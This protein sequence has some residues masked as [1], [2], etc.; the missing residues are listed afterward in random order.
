MSTWQAVWREPAECTTD[1]PGLEVQDNRVSGSINV[2]P[3][4]LPLWA[5]VHEVI[6][7]GWEEAAEDYNITPDLLTQRQFAGFLY[8]LLEQRGELGRL[9]CILADVE[10][11]E[12]EA[13]EDD[14]DWVWWKWPEHRQRVIDQL[15]RCATMLRAM[16][17]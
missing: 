4:R 12:H 13:S 1:Y 10:R 8:C 16:G 9:L 3:T 7:D 15:D 17:G 11:Q 2:G 6:E 5:I 14:G